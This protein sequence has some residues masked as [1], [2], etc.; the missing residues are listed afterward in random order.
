MSLVSRLL[1][2]NYYFMSKIKCFLTVFALLLL[3][4][5]CDPKTDDTQPDTPRYELI[6][7]IWKSEVHREDGNV[8]TGADYRELE[9]REDGTVLIEEFEED[10]SPIDDV[11]DNWALVEGDEKIQFD[12][13][14]LYDVAKMTTDSMTLEYDRP[15]PFSGQLVRHSDDFLK[16]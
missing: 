12:T 2:P 13:E 6:I 1:S 14:G 11:E 4:A 5:A 16:Q 10:G 8:I 15:D 3:V 9:F 7:G